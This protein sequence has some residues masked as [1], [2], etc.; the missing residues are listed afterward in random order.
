MAGQAII[1]NKVK[2]K[3]GKEY[4]LHLEFAETSENI[5][6]E[7]RNLLKEK[8]IIE[9]IGWMQKGGKALPSPDNEKEGSNT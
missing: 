3:S 6:E 7:I 1:W 4:T 8:V 5:G 2:S 9:K